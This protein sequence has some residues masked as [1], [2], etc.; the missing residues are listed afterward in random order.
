MA[1]EWRG[2]ER[3]ECRGRGDGRGGIGM[4]SALNIF[5]KSAPM[6]KV[7]VRV[8]IVKITRGSTAVLFLLTN[9]LKNTSNIIS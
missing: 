5:S 7:S 2:K 9:M 3:R 6:R 8:H 4:D 1:E